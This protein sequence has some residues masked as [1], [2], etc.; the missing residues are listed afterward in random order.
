MFRNTLA[1]KSLPLGTIVKLLNVAISIWFCFM[2]NNLNALTVE[3]II[4]L[5]EAGVDDRTIQLLVER[6]MM[7]RENV[8]GIGVREIERPDGSRDKTYFSVVSPEEEEKSKQ[9]EEKL[10]KAYEILRNVIID[11]RTK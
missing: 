2:V 9:E 7:K 6:E 4:R 8:Q 5:K 1:P 10:K 3:E 11:Q